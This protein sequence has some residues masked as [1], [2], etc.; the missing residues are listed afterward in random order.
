MPGSVKRFRDETHHQFWTFTLPTTATHNLKFKTTFSEK[1]SEIFTPAHY[2]EIYIGVTGYWTGPLAPW[3]LHTYTNNGN[4]YLH[5]SSGQW[6]RLVDHPF[7]TCYY[8]FII[9]LYIPSQFTFPVY[10]IYIEIPVISAWVREYAVP[11]PTWRRHSAV[12]HLATPQCRAPPG[13]TTV[14]RNPSV[15]I[16][17][18]KKELGLC[19]DEAWKAERG[20]G[21]SGRV[22][23]PLF[24]LPAN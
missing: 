22:N 23:H 10:Y 9:H 3:S 2:N 21:V 11:C 17:I 1:F 20:C 5:I 12:P 13:D 19:F 24:W 16:I 18:V 15:W 14:Q 4:F 7:S 8:L 6:Y